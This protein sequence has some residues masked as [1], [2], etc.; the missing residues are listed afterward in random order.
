M[1]NR[2]FWVKKFFKSLNYRFLFFL[3]YRVTSL[4]KMIFKYELRFVAFHLSL[5]FIVL[6]GHNFVSDICKT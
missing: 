1:D 4:T 3:I 6:V 2:G 5:Y